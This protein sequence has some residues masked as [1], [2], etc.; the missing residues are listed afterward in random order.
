[1]KNKIL[2]SLICGLLI[3]GITT[4]CGKQANSNG[5][6]DKDMQSTDVVDWSEFKINLDSMDYNYPYSISQF[7]AN[8]WQMDVDY[9]D[10]INQTIS[11]AGRVELTEEE[12]DLYKQNNIDIESIQK[13]I[14]VYLNKNNSTIYLCVDNTPSETLVKNANVI[15]LST[16]DA[17]FSF[18]GIKNNSTIED[19]KRLFGTKNYE[20]DETSKSVKAEYHNS[21]SYYESYGQVLFMLDNNAKLVKEIQITIK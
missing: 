10:I 11:K 15:Y 7:L 5:S 13:N 21:I 8:N 3:L 16:S 19:V 14:C 6:N 1:M 18:Y 9:T 12:K 2:L 4:G 17:N 20:M